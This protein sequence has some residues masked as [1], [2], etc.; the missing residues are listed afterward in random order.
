MAGLIAIGVGCRKSC[1]PTKSATFKSSARSCSGQAGE[2][3]AGSRRA[4]AC[5]AA[6]GSCACKGRG[7]DSA[8]AAPGAS[9]RSEQ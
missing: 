1:T 4:R 6:G 7:S 9:P 8:T 5:R 3:C 2:A